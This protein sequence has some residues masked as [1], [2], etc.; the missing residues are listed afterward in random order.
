MTFARMV[1]APVEVSTCA[2]FFGSV[3]EGDNGSNSTKMGD[4]GPY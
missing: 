3:A 2:K 1:T 4:D